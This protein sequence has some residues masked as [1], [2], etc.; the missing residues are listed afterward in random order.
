MSELNSLT[1][2][3]VADSVG[4][5]Y[6]AIPL[7][8]GTLE[9]KAIHLSIDDIADEFPNF[10]AA[11]I[12]ARDMQIQPVRS[13]ALEALIGT[14]E[15]ACRDRFH[16]IPL[17]QIEGIAAWRDAYKRFGIKKTSYRS[18]VE[19][20]VKNVLAERRLP[21]IST[22]VDCYN[23]VSLQHVFPVGA[24]DVD[25]IQQE[26]SF[27]YSREGDTFLPLGQAE[28]ANDPP[29]VGEVVLASG[30][31]VLCRRW[32][33]YQDARS[34]ITPDTA[35]ALVTIQ[36]QGIGDLQKAADDLVALL[37]EFCGASCQVKIVSTGNR[38]VELD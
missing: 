26:A 20:L 37:T 8:S 27:R 21:A 2:R 31:N 12:L 4:Q 18:S 38:V 3:W 16:D 15:A 10:E 22:F 9:A 33:W 24:D 6:Q 35:Q 19:R 25:K 5:A 23:A 30:S 28:A 7:E 34:P 32:N 36:S 1:D 17:S 11:V 29:K 13:P 14:R